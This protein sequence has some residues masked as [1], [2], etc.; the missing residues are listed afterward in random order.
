MFVSCEPST[1][2]SLALPSNCTIL[3]A[4]VPT[5]T[6]NVPAAVIGP[7]VNPVPEPTLVTEPVPLTVVGAYLEFELSQAS[8][9]PSVELLYVHLLNH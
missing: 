8:I 2:G 3:L 9:C 4:V 7:P 6:A 5:S 1:A